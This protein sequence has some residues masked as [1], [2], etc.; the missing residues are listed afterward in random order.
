MAQPQGPVHEEFGRRVRRQRD[1]L[2]LTQ[3]EIA[4]RSG[5]HVSYVAQVERGERNLSL[6]NILRVADALDLDPCAL[7]AGLKPPLA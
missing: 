6:T 7:V 5:L 3:E 4:E 1:V 2:G